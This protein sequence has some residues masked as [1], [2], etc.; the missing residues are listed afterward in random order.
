MREL[1]RMTGLSGVA[2]LLARH[3]ATAADPVRAAALAPD[4]LAAGAAALRPVWATHAETAVR[5]VT[6]LCGAAP[7]LAPHLRRH[8]DWLARLVRDALD[9]TRTPD[10]YDTR[11]AAALDG[12]SD[13]ARGLRRFK[14]YELARITLRDLWAA[15]DDVAATEAVL[16]ELSHLAD[17]LLA[18]ALRRALARVAADAGPA[19]WT[20]PGGTAL[21]PRFAVLGMGKLGGEELNY[22]SDV[23]LVYVLEGG[24]AE[25]GPQALSPAE[26]YGRVARELGRLVTT[27]TGDGFLYR[28]DLDLRPEG[29]AGP[30][31]VPGEM[32]AEYYDAWAATWEKAAFMKARPVAGDHAFGWRVIRA[33]DPM[34]YRSA[35]DYA[36]VEAIRAMKDRVEQ[37]VGR[38]GGTFNVKI[39]AGGIRDVE[40]VAQALQLLHGGRIRDARERSTQR[41]LT[42][43][44]QV[45]VLPVRVADDLRRHYAFLRR[46]ENRLQMVG[47]RQTHRLPEDPTERR[48]LA[49]ALGFDGPDPCAAFEAALEACRSGIRAAFTE[50]FT[51]EGVQP[52]LDLF[53]R[54]APQ[55]LAQPGTRVMI[56]RLAAQFAHAIDAAPNRERAMNN[57]DRFIRGVGSRSFY[58]GLLL[59][60]PELVDRLAGLFAASE[61]L[62]GYLATHP[63]LIEPIFSDPN[64]LVL[65][66]DAAPGA[67]ELRAALGAEQHDDEPES[68]WRRC[69]RFGRELVNI[70]LLDLAEKIGIHA[71][72]A[73]LTDLAEVCIEH[74]RWRA[75][76][77]APRRTAARRRRRLSRRG[78]G[79]ARQPRALRRKRPRRDLPLRRARGRRDRDPRDPGIPCAWRR[80]SSGRCRPAP[81]TAPAT[82]STR[83]CGRRATRACWSPRAPASPPTTPPAPRCGNSRPSCA[84]PAVGSAARRRGFRCAPARHPAA[85]APRRRRR[86]DP[87]HPPAHGGG[88]GRGGRPAPR[89]QDRPWRYARRRERRAVPAVAP[90]RAAPGAAHR[91]P[92]QRAHR[93]VGPTRPARRGRRRGAGRL[94]LPRTAIEPPAYR[95]EPVDLRPRRGTRRPRRHR[96]ATGLHLAAARRRRAARAAGRLPPAHQRDPRGVR[97]RA[98]L[99]NIGDV[100]AF[101]TLRPTKCPKRRHPALRVAAGGALAADAPHLAEDLRPG[102]GR[103]RAGGV[104]APD[105]RHLADAGDPGSARRRAARRRS[106]SDRWSGAAPPPRRSAPSPP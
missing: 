2:G 32:L 18:A 60:R 21:A 98:G 23:D 39:G 71:A 72:E 93:P 12:E 46:T 27:T 37:E 99:T 25:G 41:A 70:G 62:S 10:E 104:V 88:A 35:M 51:D 100:A 83:G 102:A 61:Y 52:L 81:A 77:R 105:D 78:R 1:E 92:H 5:A 47:E 79:Q 3:V 90:R 55:L 74:P 34:I 65:S 97:A 82:R 29:Q 53:Q 38:S 94:D 58:Y 69:G 13:D 64:V 8:G 101:R 57:L 20:A 6:T 103:H 48:A 54:N 84:R 49:R 106:P 22:S 42:A 33:V 96:H 14:Y 59:D 15:P 86:R 85:A 80:S 24:A 56:E 44:A 50:L 26:Y 30:L 40:F 91:R 68:A 9:A 45:G 7:F 28:V 11:L 36:G 31:V 4:V 19:R 87:P 76:A 73:G 63:R 43:L 66:R 16:G 67:G 17:A 95:R 75:R 89:F